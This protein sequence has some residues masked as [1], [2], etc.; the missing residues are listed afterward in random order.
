MAQIYNSDPRFDTVLADVS[1]LTRVA[2]GQHVDTFIGSSIRKNKDAMDVRAD[3]LQAKV[4]GLQVAHRGQ[5]GRNSP[6]PCQS[7]LKFKKCCIGRAHF[8]G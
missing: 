3:E 5:I 6:C 8:T 4:P 2:P 1:G 7:G